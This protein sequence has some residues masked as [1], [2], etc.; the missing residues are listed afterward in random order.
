MNKTHED[1]QAAFAGESQANRR[2]LAFAKKAE[3]E[4]KRGIARLF[5]V[6]AAGETVHAL[7]HF[8][9][10]EGVKSTA[11][12]LQEAVAGETYESETMY[13]NFL[14]DAEREEEGGAITSFS[15]ALA[16]EKIHK[17]LFEEALTKEAAGEMVPDGDF[18]ICPVCGYPASPE[19]PDVCPIC[20]AKKELFTYV[21]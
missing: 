15:L 16:V 19:A 20:G 12:N 2:Y 3:V 1:L 8:R 11:E 9:T 21:D 7:N 4:G 18:Y 6:A 13:P 5:R 17:R 14:K 10:M